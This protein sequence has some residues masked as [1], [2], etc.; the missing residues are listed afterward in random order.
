M[1]LF[2]VFGIQNPLMVQY[3]MKFKDCF[4]DNQDYLKID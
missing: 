3:K 2:K 4:Y 1:Q